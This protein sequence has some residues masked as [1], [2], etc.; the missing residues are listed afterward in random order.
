[1]SGLQRSHPVHA[2]HLFSRAFRIPHS[3]FRIPH[4]A[5]RIPHSAF[6]IP[7]SAFRI[8]NRPNCLKYLYLPIIGLTTIIPD[9]DNWQFRR[10][11][12]GKI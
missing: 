8:A 7:H 1:M 10:C 6:R 5:F 11:G 4:S 12:I 9:L 3:A 2:N